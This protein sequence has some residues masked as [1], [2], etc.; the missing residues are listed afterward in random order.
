MKEIKDTYFASTPKGIESLL[1]KELEELN[2][3]KSEQH[4]GGVKFSASPRHIM[5]V[6]LHSRLSDRIYKE[7]YTFNIQNEAD[8]YKSSCDIQWDNLMSLN[9][10]FKITTLLDREAD[11][12]F[13]NSLF[14]SLKFKDGLA[15]TF[16]KITGKR[17][18]VDTENPDYPF[19]L[20]IERNLEGKGFK[21]SLLL[22]IVGSP[23][24]QRGYRTE[25]NRA[26]LRENLAAA[27]ISS[28]DWDSETEHFIDPMCGSG[29]ILIEAILIQRHISPS[30]LRLR[31]FIERKDTPWAFLNQSWFFK[32]RNVQSYFNKESNQVHKENQE[33]LDRDFTP[34]IYGSDLDDK[35]LKITKTN[36]RRAG[37]FKA[38]N[39][40]VIDAL[41]TRPQENSKG[42]V[43]T[44]PPYG[45]RMGRGSDLKHLYHELGENLKKNFKGY[46]AYI[47][48]GNL[49]MRKEISLQTSKRIPFYNGPIEC[50]LFKYDLF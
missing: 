42:I 39:L 7:L 15:D 40:Q 16:R 10:T 37:L 45:E 50:R 27:L 20:R 9:S 4:R 46:R 21:V 34:T 13:K 49:E 41:Q 30:F 2:I 24:G 29:T 43:L 47:F 12:F 5:R 31:N 1:L 17:P 32:N 22:N 35:A 3:E 8:L 44:N 33:A 6:V 38:V 11:S 18:N 28:T 48:T 36:L 14:L 26:P 25:G 19:L 23:L